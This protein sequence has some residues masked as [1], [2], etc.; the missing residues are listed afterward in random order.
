MQQVKS[1]VLHHSTE[2]GSSVKDVAPLIKAGKGLPIFS[3]TSHFLAG[4]MQLSG[5]KQQQVGTEV[6]ITFI[7][8]IGDFF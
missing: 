8:S 4:I 2:E 6:K 1:L 7:F 5:S 3:P